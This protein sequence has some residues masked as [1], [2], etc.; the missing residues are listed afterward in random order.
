MNNCVIKM[1]G[2]CQGKR[3]CLKKEI[4]E[5]DKTE[6]ACSRKYMRYTKGTFHFGI[7]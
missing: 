4:K 5:L 2:M 3:V 6:H 1:Y 7:L